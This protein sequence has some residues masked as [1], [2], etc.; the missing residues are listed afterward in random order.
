MI[1]YDDGLDM[2]DKMVTVMFMDVIMIGW[3]DGFSS[4]GYLFVI[5]YIY[6]QVRLV[7][8]SRRP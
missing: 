8:Q 3:E 5:L 7:T 6:I 1:Y 2:L 4:H